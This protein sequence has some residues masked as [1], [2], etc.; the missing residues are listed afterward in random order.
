MAYLKAL[1]DLRPLWSAYLK[2][3]LPILSECLKVIVPVLPRGGYTT[4]PE[5]E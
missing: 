1:M 5:R 2:L 4:F 3:F